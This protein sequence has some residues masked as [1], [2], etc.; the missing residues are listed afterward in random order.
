[1]GPYNAFIETI[2]LLDDEGVPIPVLN[3]GW[4]EEGANLDAEQCQTFAAHCE[5]V[6]SQID[7]PAKEHVKAWAASLRSVTPTGRAL[8]G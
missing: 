5:L 8:I 7:S 6:A 1:M 3:T 2:T 4:G